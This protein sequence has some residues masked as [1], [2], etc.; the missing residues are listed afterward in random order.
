MKFLPL[1][2]ITLCCLLISV[3][4]SRAAELSPE[5]QKAFDVAVD[6][7]ENATTPEEWDGAIT[8]LI[9]AHDLAPSY[10][11][12]AALLA[13]ACY[14]RGLPLTA[15][16]WAQAYLH[17]EPKGAKTE[18]VQQVLEFC[19]RQTEETQIKIF[20]AA[21]TM[22]EKLSGRNATDAD[23][24]IDDWY[25]CQRM[26][27]SSY[28]SAV[29]PAIM[30]T[31]H[32]AGV[33]ADIRYDQALS[34]DFAPFLTAE[35]EDLAGY[36]Q[37]PEQ[38]TDHLQARFDNE[39][40][41]AFFTTCLETGDW[42]GAMNALDWGYSSLTVPEAQREQVLRWG[43]QKDH[44][45]YLLA[46][47][48]ESLLTHAWEQMLAKYEEKQLIM[49]T[50]KIIEAWGNLAVELGREEPAYRS[51]EKLEKLRHA[52][53]DKD[54]N[55]DLI[56]LEVADLAVPMGK[57]VRRI[58]ALE[59]ASDDALLTTSFYTTVWDSYF[60]GNINMPK[61]KDFIAA[62]PRVI[63]ARGYRGITALHMV[64]L[65]WFVPCPLFG[66]MK[67]MTDF[68]EQDG[69][70]F[71]GCNDLPQNRGIHN[72]PPLAPAVVKL[73]L[74]NHAD[75]NARMS[76]GWTPLHVAAAGYSGEADALAI[77]QV[78]VAR[79]ATVDARANN[80]VTPLD[81]ATAQGMLSVV[82]LLIAKGSDVES[83]ADDGMT[84]L[85]YAAKRG[86]VEIAKLLVAAGADVS[87]K[88]AGGQTP[89]DLAKAGG[90]DELAGWLIAQ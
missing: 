25:A 33:M 16:A 18:K 51:E 13:S 36:L 85:H 81:V 83:A 77:A 7:S 1:L 69:R 44:A 74:D 35:Q 45:P 32:R 70:P 67:N 27:P 40:W 78:L 46:E 88:D 11:P 2:G 58:Q 76:N 21:M 72:T 34:G 31:N 4:P 60:L 9:K 6:L 57:S 82:K 50:P 41:S 75:V 49:T 90:F 26:L 29:L 80:G 39:Y 37:H 47:R 66:T 23:G 65:G 17:A 63:A 64:S 59:S 79:D 61:V 19:S 68:F 84:P 5:A 71:G 24:H 42:Q 62:N 89:A 20:A 87:T 15:V 73:L 54:A 14:M 43:Y 53:E 3:W 86:H 55:P 8:A 38:G 48:H 56:P 12:T 10:A 30:F 22:A 28:T 52:T